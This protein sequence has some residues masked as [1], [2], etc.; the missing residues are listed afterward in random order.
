VEPATERIRMGEENSLLL[1]LSEIEQK[2]QPK[3]EEKMN[4]KRDE[5]AE[6]SLRQI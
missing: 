5:L 6:K 4:Q 1:R 3:A 2:K